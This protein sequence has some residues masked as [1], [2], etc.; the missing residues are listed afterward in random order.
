MTDERPVEDDS[1]AVDLP[2]PDDEAAD[3]DIGFDLQHAPVAENDNVLST[4]APADVTPSLTFT[5]VDAADT[6]A[7]V[8]VVAEMPAPA[9]AVAV[10]PP[11]QTEQVS[12]PECGR[13]ATVTLTRRESV[14]F[15]TNCDYPLFWTPSKILVDRSGLSDDSLRRL[16]GTVGRVA[17]ASFPCPHCAELNQVS[18]VDCIR[19]GRPLRPVHFVAPAPVYVPPPPRPEPEPEPRGVPWWVWAVIAVAVAIAVVLIVLAENG[20]FN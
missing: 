6:T 1:T 8:R 3:D 14:D 15:C 16:P 20:V 17:I 12:C 11:P 5:A 18:A 2:R 4:S 13:V 10:L 7:P 9:P 19:C